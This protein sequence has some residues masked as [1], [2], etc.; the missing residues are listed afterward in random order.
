MK[1]ATLLEACVERQGVIDVFFAYLEYSVPL[2]FVVFVVWAVVFYYPSRSSYLA[3]A[4]LFLNL[5]LNATLKALLLVPRPISMCGFGPAMPSARAQLGAYL[6]LQ[7]CMRCEW[8]RRV[9]LSCVF[10]FLLGALGSMLTRSLS[11][12][13][14]VV[15]TVV[16]AFVYLLYMMAHVGVFGSTLSSL[17]FLPASANSGVATHPSAHSRRARMAQESLYEK[18]VAV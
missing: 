15:G 18:D 2:S 9:V 17:P 1:T 12:S 6:F 14:V 4:F 16:G 8:R 7:I 10:T 5:V 3:I 11:A 13:D